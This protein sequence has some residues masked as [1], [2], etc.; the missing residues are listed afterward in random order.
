MYWFDNAMIQNKSKSIP[1]CDYKR[2]RTCVKAAY[3][4]KE[5]VA[6]LSE[7]IMDPKLLKPMHVWELRL[8][9]IQAFE[10]LCL[11][12]GVNSCTGLMK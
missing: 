3:N 4:R 1:S 2:L 8:L 11:E 12:A 6:F 7:L 5:L 10:E 9:A